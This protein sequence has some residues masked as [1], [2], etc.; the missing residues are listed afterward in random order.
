MAF[1]AGALLGAG[2][3][4]L[5]LGAAAPAWSVGGA[6]LAI[7]LVV[8]ARVRAP[9]RSS[10][11]A[12]AL[13]G[14]L[15]GHFAAFE[16]RAAIERPFVYA[17]GV[18]AAPLILCGAAEALAQRFPGAGGQIALRVAGSWIAAVGLLVVALAAI[19]G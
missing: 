13:L 3:G 9:A 11:A 8:A 6:A 14:L 7:A 18:G 12:A 1:G 2:A 5:G 15:Q 16:D 10:L 4:L 17:L 19:Q